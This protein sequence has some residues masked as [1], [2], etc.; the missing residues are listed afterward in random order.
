MSLKK[1]KK[2][3]TRF[4]I[5]NTTLTAIMV[6][7]IS[8]TSFLSLVVHTIKGQLHESD[9][10]SPV[11]IAKL[12]RISLGHLSYNYDIM[13]Y[14][15]KR[16]ISI[17]VVTDSNHF[18]LGKPLNFKG[19]DKKI[20]WYYDKK[21]GLYRYRK[22]CQTGRDYYFF[23]YIN[24]NDIFERG[25]VIL[26]I[27]LAFILLTFIITS[28][29]SRKI[30][31]PISA[32]IEKAKLIDGDNLDIR[33][34][35]V[36]ND[37]LG[38]L[39]EIINNTLSKIQKSYES[40][41]NFIHNAS[42]ELKT[43]LAVIKGYLEI[44]HWSKNNPTINNEALENAELEVSNMNN[45]INQLFILSKLENFKVN[46]TEFEIFSLFSKIENDYKIL[47]INRIEFKDS[48]ELFF[49]DKQLTLES[50]RILVD[51][52]L[53]FSKD[54]I[55]LSSYSDKDFQYISVKD[56]GIGI[57]EQEINKIFERF[58]KID[59][60]RSFKDKGLGLG[61]S[62]VDEI[63]NSQDGKIYVKSSPNLGSEFIMKFKKYNK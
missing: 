6:L 18:Y 33:L 56:F 50:L 26:L 38:E 54:N 25:S 15:D 55:L 5:L 57:D 4:V 39:V 37:E 28:I 42:H 12:D 19:S 46:K 51:N 48:S 44:L 43:P 61:L 36:T 7:L 49:L 14:D 45:V 41:K 63:I 24:I 27:D 21:D 53:K 16:N 10:Y 29:G 31:E 3:G 9:E 8:T 13:S 2:I 32:V 11:L 22:Y 52:A 17:F 47:N 40:Q 58:Y 20:G 59:N 35:K 34:P 23:N 1:G 60:S 30:L 62:I